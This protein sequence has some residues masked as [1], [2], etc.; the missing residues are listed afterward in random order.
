[1]RIMQIRR[2]GVKHDSI[3]PSH[4]GCQTSI[5]PGRI[6]VNLTIAHWSGLNLYLEMYYL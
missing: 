1:M 6:I 4:V 2:N 3:G 5:L